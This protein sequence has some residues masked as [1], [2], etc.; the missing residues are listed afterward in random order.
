MDAPW[1]EAKLYVLGKEVVFREPE[2]Q[3]LRGVVSRQFVTIPLRSIEDDVETK[4]R[5]LKE[6]SV[7][8]RSG[9]SSGD[10][11]LFTTRGGRR[12]AYPHEGYFAI[13]QSWLLARG[14]Y[15]GIPEPY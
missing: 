1:S 13:S 5:Q 11:T 2:T 15:S 7:P 12:H 14:D 8:I 4:V 3:Q 10:D 9:K 6:R